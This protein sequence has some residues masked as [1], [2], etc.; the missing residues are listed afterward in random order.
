MGNEVLKNNSSSEQAISQLIGTLKR[1]EAPKDFDFRVNARI[2]AGKPVDRK[3]SWLP[4]L[5]RYAVPLGLLL[6]VGGYFGLNAIYSPQAADVPVVAE[7]KA[8]PAPIA[9]APP[10][11]TAPVN[12]S[13]VSPANQ[14]VAVKTESAPPSMVN[15]TVIREP[16]KK[17]GSPDKSTERGGG[18]IDSASRDIKIITPRDANTNTSV[19]PGSNASVPIPT[20]STSEILAR[21]GVRMGSGGKVESV[22]P[23]SAASRSGL[24][25]GDIIESVGGQGKSLRVRRDGKTV[26]VGISH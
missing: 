13:V 10:V 11:I 14:T 16:V 18:S 1:I 2:A 23:G 26:L 20:L 15:K 22:A 8:Q 3:V 6:V 24:K 4:A 12:E 19:Q 25:A 17:T 7:T 21:L 9:V 5:V